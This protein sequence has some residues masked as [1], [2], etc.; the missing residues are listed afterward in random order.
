MIFVT[1]GSAP[2]PRLVTMVE[3]VAVDLNDDVLIQTADEESTTKLDQVAYLP[4]A[5]YRSIVHEARF[6]ISHAGIGTILTSIEKDTPIIVV[7]RRAEYGEHGDNHQVA[8][9]ERFERDGLVTVARSSEELWSIIESEGYS[10]DR[11]TENTLSSY[12]EDLIRSA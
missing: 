9:A 10:M 1:T 6:V 4:L 7:P 11:S 2:F 8:T 5:E 3:A 12:V